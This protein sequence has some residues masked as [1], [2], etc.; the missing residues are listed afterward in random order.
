MYLVHTYDL[1]NQGYNRLDRC[2]FQDRSICIVD[3]GMVWN[4][5]FRNNQGEDNLQC[6][7]KYSTWT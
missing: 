1:G 4:S 2:P 5:C 3:R 6:D 7:K